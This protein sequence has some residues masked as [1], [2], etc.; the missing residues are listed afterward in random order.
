MLACVFALTACGSTS[1]TT[2]KSE[3]ALEYSQ[4]NI[5]NFVSKYLTALSGYSDDDLETEYENASEGYDTIIQSWM[6]NKEH[7][8]TFVE[9]TNYD[10]SATSKAVT[11]T[12]DATY[13]DRTCE[14]RMTIDKDSAI[15]SASFTPNYSLAEKMEKA[16]LNTVIGMGTV[17]VVLIFIS[18]LISLFKYINKFE[19]A[20]KDKKAAANSATDVVDNTVA[21]IIQKEENEIDETDDLEL[22]AVITAAIAASEGTSADG[23]VVRSIKRVNKSKWQRA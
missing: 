12:A 9:I 8:G 16:G 18:F 1:T 23:L 10:F 21:Q 5:E 14:F 13:S 19:Q 7:L 4:D 20:M 17:F 3:K 11:V 22:V 2:K 15:T 6:T